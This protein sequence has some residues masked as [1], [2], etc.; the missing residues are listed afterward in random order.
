MKQNESPRK[1]KFNVSNDSIEWAHWTWNPVTGCKHDCKYCYARDIANRFY[2]QGFEPTFHQDRLDAPKNTPMDSRYP[3]NVFVCSMADLFGD[4]VPQEWIDRVLDVCWDH[5]EWN[6]IFLTKNP[7]RLPTIKWP[8]NAWVGATVDVQ[9]RV[10]PTIEALKN[11]KARVRFVSCEPLQEP[12]TFDEMPFEWIIIGG[13]S[14]SSGEPEFYP[15]SSWIEDLVAQAR[16][17]DLKVYQKP[18]LFFS[19]D[20]LRL[21]EYPKVVAN[22]LFRFLEGVRA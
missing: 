8:P 14:R 1:S 10:Q 16:Q 22:G 15:Q 9:S 3:L 18:N 12:I 11:V 17:H 21:Q 20:V 6:F 2:E 7:K 4:W 5:S 19:D 13:R